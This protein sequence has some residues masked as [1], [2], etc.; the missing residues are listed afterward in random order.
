[1]KTLCVLQH[2]EA[3]FLGLMEDHLEGRSIRF[4]YV[5]PFAAGTILPVEAGGFDGLVVLGAGPR[6]IVSGDLVPSLGPELRLTRDFLERHLP[7][8]GIG[9]GACLLA[10]A[11]GGG[12]DTAPLRF[13]VGVAHR[14]VAQALDG[15]LPQSYPLAVYMRD[16]PVLPAA[17]RVLAVDE[18]GEPALFQIRENCLGFT[19]H[20]G[21]KS[22]MI[23]DLIME[24]DEVP[25]GTAEML[26]RL[27]AVQGEIAAAL[28][29]IM[30]GIVKA[31]HLMEPSG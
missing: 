13:E 5:R 23:E 16:R 18:A 20:P 6:G 27:R 12:A 26:V 24:F 15:H 21:I 7:V 9:F 2:T 1:M 19:G 4:Q 11:A 10:A 17:A 31:A 3:E 14:A 29:D 28:S 25:G 30:V 22:A 8:I